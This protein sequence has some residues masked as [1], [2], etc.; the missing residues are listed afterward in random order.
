MQFI[1]EYSGWEIVWFAKGNISGCLNLMY[2]RRFRIISRPKPTV[3]I[4]L[5]TLNCDMTDTYKY[6]IKRKTMPILLIIKFKLNNISMILFSSCFVFYCYLFV[7]STFFEI[8][9]MFR[10]GHRHGRKHSQL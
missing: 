5:Y 6:L 7:S 3:L 8:F 1:V 4:E 9:E 10:I 2:V